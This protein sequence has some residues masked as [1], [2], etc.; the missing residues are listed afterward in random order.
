[1][2]SLDCQAGNCGHNCDGKCTANTIEIS[3]NAVQTFC[4]TYV[5]QDQYAADSKTAINNAFKLEAGAEAFASPKILCNVGE[6][7][8]N[9][10][11]RCKANGVQIDNSKANDVFNCMTYKHE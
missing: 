9:K 2:R 11:S 4:N 1:M 3:N 5:H 8:H 6:C 7:I 10:S